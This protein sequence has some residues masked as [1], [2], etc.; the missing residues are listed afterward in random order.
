MK[1]APISQ[2]KKI[3]AEVTKESVAKIREGRDAHLYRLAQAQALIR[4]LHAVGVS[5]FTNPDDVPQD[6]MELALK[7]ITGRDGKICP[8]MEDFQAVQER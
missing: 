7:S 5:Q 3:P 6:K 1:H 4:A 2:F 8:S